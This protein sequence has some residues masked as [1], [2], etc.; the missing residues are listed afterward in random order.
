MYEIWADP[1]VQYSRESCGF[2]R[3]EVDIGVHL[4][5]QLVA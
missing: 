5:V 4:V 1:G 2:V 3:L